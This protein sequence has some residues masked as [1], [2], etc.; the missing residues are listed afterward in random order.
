MVTKP[1]N[2]TFNSIIDCCIRCNQIEKAEEIFEEMKLQTHLQPDL[3]SYS[4]MIKGFC[5]A[6][7]IERA[8]VLLEH[9]KT[10]DIKPDEVLFNSLL[11]GCC[12]ANLIDV[13]L[14][15]YKN[16]VNLKI[17]PSNVTFSILIKIYGKAGNLQSAL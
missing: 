17:K 12:R 4:T 5:K 11:D 2:V 10:V 8:L 3:I 7:N 14:M 6:G 1:N 13:G 16:M 9:M 15:V